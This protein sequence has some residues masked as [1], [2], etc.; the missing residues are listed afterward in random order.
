[1]ALAK[2]NHPIDVENIESN[3]IGLRPILSDNAPRRGALKKA[4]KENTEKRIVIV[5]AD[6]PNSVR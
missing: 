4:Q 6:A 3:K 2:T 1:M 5:N